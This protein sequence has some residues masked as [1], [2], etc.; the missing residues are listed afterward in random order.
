MPTLIDTTTTAAPSWHDA[1][2]HE[3]YFWIDVGPF[4]D[5]F[6]ASALAITGSTDP[7]VQ[8]MVTLTMPR[9]FIDLRRKDLEP[10]MQM[11]ISKGLITS[12][13]AVTILDP[14]TTEQERHIKN[15]PQPTE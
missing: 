14:K 12:E 2:I 11:L 10:M 1:N 8:G 13:Q 6:G 5:R 9:K 7:Q 4:F 3:A 15:M